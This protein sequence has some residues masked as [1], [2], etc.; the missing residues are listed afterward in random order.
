MSLSTAVLNTRNPASNDK[1]SL[2]TCNEW[3][4]HTTQV[5]TCI[6]SVGNQTHAITTICRGTPT[7]YWL[8]KLEGYG[9]ILWLLFLLWYNACPCTIIAANECQPILF[10]DGQKR[11]AMVWRVHRRTDLD[12]LQ[13]SKEEVLRGEVNTRQ[14]SARLSSWNW[15]NKLSSEIISVPLHLF[16]SSPVSYWI[17]TGA[18]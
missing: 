7:F 18:A 15:M 11:D 12:L 10:R 13:L 4:T 8:S 6:Y 1:S 17:Q 9:F 3:Y 16:R 14:W 5:G 2:I